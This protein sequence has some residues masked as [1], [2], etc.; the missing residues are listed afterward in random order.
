MQVFHS[1]VTASEITEILI[2]FL[3]F[4]WR[5]TSTFRFSLWTDR[6]GSFILFLSSLCL[7]PLTVQWLKPLC[8]GYL[9][10]TEVAPEL[11]N[12]NKQWLKSSGILV[13]F[14][15][16]SPEGLLFQL[17]PLWQTAL[18]LWFL[19]LHVCSHTW[20]IVARVTCGDEGEPVSQPES[21][22]SGCPV[23]VL[24]TRSLWTQ[25][26]EVVFS[27]TTEGSEGLFFSCS[28][29]MLMQFIQ[30]CVLSASL[31]SELST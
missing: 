12:Q 19:T 15:F 2:V 9:W 13:I 28:E 14:C 11:C 4:L 30:H 23:F 3:L 5:T 6:L 21:S 20:L 29:K 7:L 8:L 24:S 27:Y 31:I 18:L 10:K 22:G 17:C 16:I 25:L 26:Y 1:V